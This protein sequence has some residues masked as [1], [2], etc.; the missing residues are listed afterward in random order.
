MSYKL[1]NY[2]F[3][4]NILI[5]IFAVILI[6]VFLNEILMDNGTCGAKIETNTKPTIENIPNNPNNTSNIPKYKYDA[7]KHMIFVKN[8][9]YL[10]YFKSESEHDTGIIKELCDTT[11]SII[12]YHSILFHF[13][14]IVQ[15]NLHSIHYMSNIKSTDISTDD[16]FGS[17]IEIVNRTILANNLL[18][19]GRKNKKIR[20]VKKYLK[21]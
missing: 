21:K 5:L 18:D 15:E 12:F 7:V 3:I 6:H 10:K 14:P 1:D 13:F 17:L 11:P 2:L 9:E 8:T 4:K 19:G 20:K 16:S